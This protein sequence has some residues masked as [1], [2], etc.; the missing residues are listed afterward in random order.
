MMH[1]KSWSLLTFLCILVTVAACAN[2][3]RV[4]INAGWN[5]PQ[6]CGGHVW[7][8][9]AFAA[10]QDG[11]DAVAHGGTVTVAAGAYPERLVIAKPLSLIGPG[12]GID[13]NGTER[14]NPEREARLFPPRHDLTET[15]GIIVTV[16]ADNVTLAGFTIDGDNPAFMGNS[17]SLL[18]LN[19]ADINAASGISSNGERCQGILIAH[20]IIKNLLCYGV[21][22]KN[23]KF[24]DQL[25]GYSAILYNKF[26]N[27]PKSSWPENP[28][29]MPPIWGTGV[30]IQREYFQVSHNTFTRVANGIDIHYVS[31]TQATATPIV[32]HNNIE[33]S[34]EGIG[35]H[36]LQDHKR[37]SGPEA[38]VAN[39]V[40]SITSVRE[41]ED[42]FPTA[43]LSICGI[44]IQ[45]KVLAVDNQLSGGDA[46]VIFFHLPTFNPTNVTIAN[47]TID[48]ARYGVWFLNYFAHRQFGAARASGA[49]LS[50]VTVNNPR[51]AGIYLRDEPNGDGPVTLTTRGVTVHGGPVGLRLHGPRTVIKGGVNLVGQ[52]VQPIVTEAGARTPNQ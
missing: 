21:I 17:E 26:D 40:I 48:N 44:D 8:T 45:A 15:G 22:F 11:I 34:L 10:I 43:G 28:Q 13:P 29:H 4:F 5:G 51:E 16:N 24:P 39:N 2:P 14:A 49:L 38:L 32:T 33:A 31:S 19:D 6:N 27:L 52:T 30:W 46:G 36:L 37:Q 3:T 47:T 20:N 12:A 35:L 7:Q 9:D 18:W 41:T 1:G 50:G 42:A 25:D 23:N